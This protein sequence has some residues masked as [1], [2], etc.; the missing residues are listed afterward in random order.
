MHANL[1][2][3]TQIAENARKFEKMHANREE[4][5]QNRKDARES[6]K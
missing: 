6:G 5:T 1:K 3:C 4:C 2:R